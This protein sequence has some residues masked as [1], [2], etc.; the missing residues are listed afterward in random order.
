MR[1]GV[2]KLP[3]VLLEKDPNMV[4]NDRYGFKDGQLE[5]VESVAVQ[6]ERILSMYECTLEWVN[7][8]P[9]ANPD[10]PTGSLAKIVTQANVKPLTES[11]T[12]ANAAVQPKPVEGAPKSVTQMSVEDGAKLAEAAKAASATETKTV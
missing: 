3:Q 5:V 2:F 10:A 6:I 4:I 1:I 12:A 9:V 8:E 7:A 11:K